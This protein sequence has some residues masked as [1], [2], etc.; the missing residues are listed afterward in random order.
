MVGTGAGV[1][2]LLV[3]A[4]L[5]FATET[6]RTEYKEQV[7][8]IC[9]ASATANRT[10]LAGA[11]DQVRQG[12]LKAAAVKFARAADALKKTYRELNA[13]PRPT[14]DAT[15]LS[16][17][18]SYVSTEVELLDSVSKALRAGEPNKARTYVAKLT[19]NANL[20]NSQIVI[21]DLNSCM[22]KPAQYT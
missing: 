2:L 17:W 20:A 13:V 10:I 4:S 21:F 16:K 19:H 14:A 15:R 11:R 12:K 9:K 1:I 3:V 6:T 18:L 7:E 5:A 8:P 22:F